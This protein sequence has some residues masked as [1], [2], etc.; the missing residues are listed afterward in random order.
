LIEICH[1]FENI[2]F[3]ASI[4][5]IVKDVYEEIIKRSLTFAVYEI[6]EMDACFNK[7]SNLGDLKFLP[8]LK[9][10]MSEFK[11]KNDD[12]MKSEFK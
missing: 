2:N 3:D 12:K 9:K 5:H 8:E 7:F 4:S 6:D 10:K 1:L 11:V